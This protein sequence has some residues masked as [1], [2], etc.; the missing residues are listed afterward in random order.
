MLLI[1]PIN[2]AKCPFPSL[3]NTDRPSSESEKSYPRKILVAEDNPINQRLATHILKNW[4]H[5]VV[6][7]STGRQAVE[8]WESEPFDLILMDIQMP[9]MD[10]L[11]ATRVIRAKESG[12]ARHTPIVAMTAHVMSGDRE[13]C[14]TAGMDEY[15]T[16]PIRRE[17][18]RE[19]IE[20]LTSA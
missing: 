15:L 8:A 9:D 6:V 12:T 20:K 11:E 2:G 17:E 13:N 16:K 18:L 5:S 10:G 4:G 3:V 7:T 14:L 19:A 1:G